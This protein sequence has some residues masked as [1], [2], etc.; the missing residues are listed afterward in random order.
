MKEEIKP[1][2]VDG[3]EIPGYFVSNL[4]KVYCTKHKVGMGK[5]GFRTIIDD[6]RMFELSLV[7]KRVK[8]KDYVSAQVGLTIP[9]NVLTEYDYARRRENNQRMLKKYVHQLVMSAFRPIDDY[10]PIPKDEWDKCPESAKKWIKETVIINHID[11]NPLNNHVDNLEYVTARENSRKAVQHY[12]GHTANKGKLVSK[13]EP[14]H[15]TITL[16]DFV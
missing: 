1:V 5:L 11:H 10:P 7:M 14:T 13:K 6:S 9:D 16:L 2:I 8:G 4:G 12:G 15:R 3:E